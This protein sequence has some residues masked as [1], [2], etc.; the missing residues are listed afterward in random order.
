[1]ERRAILDVGGPERFIGRGRMVN[2]DVGDAEIVSDRQL[3]QHEICGKLASN[4]N[5]IGGQAGSHQA[6]RN[7]MEKSRRVALPQRRPIK[8]RVPQNAAG[9]R[10]THGGLVIQMKFVGRMKLKVRLKNI[11]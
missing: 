8:C 9:L 2:L 10:I 11:I 7:L 5:N 6:I 1:M 4:A 3:A